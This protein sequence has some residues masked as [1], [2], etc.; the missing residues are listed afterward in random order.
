MD[1]HPTATV[2]VTDPTAAGDQDS[3]TDRYVTDVDPSTIDRASL[4]ARLRER[5]GAS[6]RLLDVEEVVLETRQRPDA[7]RIVTPRV[8][9]AAELESGRLGPNQSQPQTPIRATRLTE[10]LSFDA[11]P[12]VTSVELRAPPDADVRTRSRLRVNGLLVALA[13]E[14][15]PFRVRELVW[16]LDDAEY[17]RFKSRYDAGGSG[18]AGVWATDE[19]G[20]VLLV[21]HEGE[22]AWSEP[23]GKREVGETFREAGIREFREETGVEPTVTGVREVHAIVHEHAN[24]QEPSIVSPIVIFDGAATGDP[25][26]RDGEI[27]AAKWWS[28]HPDDLLYPALADFPI[29]AARD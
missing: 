8:R 21:R 13:A 15:G 1:D 19:E 22:S 20:R 25:S 16:A 7:D 14:Y 29:P 26:G 18:G 5:A 12:E 24:R 10:T 4:E 9:V 17:D 3:S 6:S 28:N 23:G 27:A 11:P 2:W